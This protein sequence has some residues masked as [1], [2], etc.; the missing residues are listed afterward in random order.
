[1]TSDCHENLHDG[2]DLRAGP[3]KIHVPAKFHEA[4]CSGLCVIVRTEKK[5]RR[6]QY[7]LSLKRTVIILK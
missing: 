2:T 4:K 5:L 1:M 7:R 3:K 6:K